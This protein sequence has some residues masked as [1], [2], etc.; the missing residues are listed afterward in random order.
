MRVSRVLCVA[1]LLTLVVA[2]CDD[3]GAS[4]DDGPTSTSEGGQVT[5]GGDATTDETDFRTTDVEQ[6]LVAVSETLETQQLTPRFANAKHTVC[7]G[8]EAD[9]FVETSYSYVAQGRTDYH[10]GMSGSAQAARAV[11]TALDSAGWTPRD[12]DWARD[13]IHAGATE[14][15]DI[16]VSKDG[17]EARVGMQAD[18]PIVLMS[19]S[20]PCI[21]PPDGKE[22]SQASKVLKLPGAV[23]FTDSAAEDDSGRPLPAR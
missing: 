2:G 3:Q 13:G 18:S 17:L 10:V 7:A 5:D 9:T 8:G 16:Y 19:V 22:P 21:P 20:G 12:D 1:A 23:P 6:A 14:R 4:P 15:W 11:V